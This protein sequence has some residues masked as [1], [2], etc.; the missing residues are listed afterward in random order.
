MSKK[1]NSNFGCIATFIFV[2]A[3]CPLIY[4]F[5]YDNNWHAIFKTWYIS[6]NKNYI[7]FFLSLDL[8]IIYL[9]LIV[10]AIFSL[11]DDS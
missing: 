9:G 11:T 2:D 7:S 1:D 4:A 8:W 3:L 10:L 6:A 5:Y